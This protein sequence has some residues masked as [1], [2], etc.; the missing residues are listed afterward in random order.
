M[1]PLAVRDGACGE[2]HPRSAGTGINATFVSLCRS[3]VRNVSAEYGCTG[4]IDGV[5]GADSWRGLARSLNN[6]RWD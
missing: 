3:G 4:P 2:R 6:D 1:R 5:M